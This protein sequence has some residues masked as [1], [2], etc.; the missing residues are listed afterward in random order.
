MYLALIACRA[1]AESDDCEPFPSFGWLVNRD[2]LSR[3]CSLEL[4][5]A[6]ATPHPWFLLRIIQK[7]FCGMGAPFLPTNATTVQL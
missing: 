1:G 6:L 4:P 3:P 2:Q 7:R 5:Q